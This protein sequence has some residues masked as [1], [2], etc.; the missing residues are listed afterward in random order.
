MNNEENNKI[1]RV[2]ENQEKIVELLHEY[3]DAI[4]EKSCDFRLVLLDPQLKQ[5]GLWEIKTERFVASG[6]L[7]RIHSW[8]NIR[9]ISSEKVL[10]FT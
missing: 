1:Q 4:K 7:K 9:N 2:K 3:K 5:Y 10:H 6:S 8:L